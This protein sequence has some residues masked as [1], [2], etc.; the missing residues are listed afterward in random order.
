MIDGGSFID[1][2]TPLRDE[3]PGYHHVVTRGNNKRTIYLDD[4]D[5]QFFCLAVTRI[6]KKYDWTVLAYC[7]MDNHYHLLISIG[8]KGLS[9]GMCELNSGYAQMFNAWHGRVNHLFGKRYWN[10][11][12]KTDASLWNTVRYIVQ[13]PRRAGGS[14]P[15]DGYRWTSYPATIGLAV[16]DI[17]LAR[18]EVLRFFDHIETRAV[19][20]F[21]RFCSASALTG[22]VWWQPP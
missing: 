20:T 12:I 7:L 9:G 15:L 5:R 4:R 11:R 21:R 14:K 22:P 19:V 10:R 16:A 6:A 1:V 2:S 13:N 18:D 17:Q 3:S 8:E